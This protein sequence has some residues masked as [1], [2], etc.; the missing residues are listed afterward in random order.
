MPVIGTGLSAG[1]TDVV[2][3]HALTRE[4]VV[5]GIDFVV[6]RVHRHSLCGMP[7]TADSDIERPGNPGRLFEKKA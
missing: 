2:D 3:Q 4:R 6:S 1:Q 5:A 7:K